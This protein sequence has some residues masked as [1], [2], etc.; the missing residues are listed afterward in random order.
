VLRIDPGTGERTVLADIAPG[1]DNLAFLD[2]RLFVSSICGQVN[3]ITAPV[4]CAPCCRD[5]FNWPL[6]LAMGDDGVLF[7]ADGPYSYTVSADGTRNVAY[8]LFSPG[9]SRL[10]HVASPL[11][12]AGE[13]IVTTANGVVARYQ[14][15]APTARGARQ[16]TSTSC[17]ASRSRL[18][19]RPIVRRTRYWARA[20]DRCGQGRNAGQLDCSDPMGVAI[21]A[22]GDLPGQSECGAG[23]VVKAVIAA[24]RYGGGRPAAAARASWCGNRCSTSSMPARRN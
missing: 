5:G 8:M 18:V 3:E 7:V 16:R 21:G 22:D 1:L 24:Y 6:D 11:Q 10:H 20:V 17:T 23:S 13:M 19:A 9:W 15:R 2:G 12:V 14:C 4:R